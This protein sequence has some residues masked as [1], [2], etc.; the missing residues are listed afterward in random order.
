[1][2]F[3]RSFWTGTSGHDASVNTHQVLASPRR[4]SRRTAILPWLIL[5]AS[6]CAL[7]AQGCG[8]DDNNVNPG[9]AGSDAAA[10]MEARAETSSGGA[11]VTTGADTAGGDTSASDGARPDAT[12]P[13]SDAM[14][15]DSARPDA[16]GGDGASGDAPPPDAQL[17]CIIDGGDASGDCCP[18][19]PFK[20]QPGVCGCG[21]SD[22]D[23]DADGT[24]DCIDL[25]PTDPTKIA[26]GI[27]GCNS[28]DVDTDGDGLLDCLDGCPRDPTRGQPGPCGC[29]FPDNTPLCLV[30][31]YT[32]DDAPAADAGATDAGAGTTVVSDSISHADGTAVNVTLTG[33]GSVTLAGGTTGQYIRLPSGIISSIGDNATFEAFV[34]WPGVGGVWQRIFD[35]GTNT[36]GAGMQG[37]GTSFL[38]LTPLGGPGV[39]L[40]SFLTPGAAVTETDS[41]G[42]FP[43][44]TMI[45]EVA[46]VLTSPVGD[47]GAAGD[48]GGATMSLY[49]D[50][51]LKVRIPANSKLSLLQDV[52]NWL[53]RSQFTADPALAATYYDFR[54]YSM[55][56]TDPQIMTSATMGPN[57]LP[58]Q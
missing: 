26:P 10:M 27:C 45:H 3:G 37:T 58:T 9:E 24:P 18:N 50:G 52:N 12:M 23:T 31:R 56:R 14:T 55:A 4:Q 33:T 30:H 42:V 15:S 35:F 39:L 47:A 19:D 21:V 34:S 11:D 2:G 40:A 41:N 7:G 20:T 8:A 28:P 36:G 25:C 29:G 48:A 17:P 43:T 38:F 22:I 54:I 44:G 16:P 32:F 1:M 51:T 6:A 5:L 13:G 49:L 46:I 57:L 53:G